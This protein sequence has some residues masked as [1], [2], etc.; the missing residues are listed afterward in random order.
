MTNKLPTPEEF[1][2]EYC[3]AGLVMTTKSFVQKRDAQILARLEEFK[4]Y[5]DERY[6]SYRIENN[7]AYVECLLFSKRLEQLIK[8]L[9]G[10]P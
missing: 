6:A 5:I 7:S 1:C 8:E 2:K 9:R 3:K 4:E 10:A